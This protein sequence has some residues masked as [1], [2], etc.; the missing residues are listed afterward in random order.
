MLTDLQQTIA[1]NQA[2]KPTCAHAPDAPGEP[3][4]IDFDHAIAQ[5]RKDIDAIIT[6]LG[7]EMTALAHLLNARMWCSIP[8]Q[9]K[10]SGSGFRAGGGDVRLIGVGPD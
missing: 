4:E 9:E 3:V 2:L 1:R 7:E 6:I 8:V 10:P 5:K